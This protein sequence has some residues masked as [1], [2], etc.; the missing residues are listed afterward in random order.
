MFWD[1]CVENFGIFMF[2]KAG[3][4]FDFD[5]LSMGGG[6]ALLLSHF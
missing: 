2:K 1:G 3:K 6:G 4:Y 5:A